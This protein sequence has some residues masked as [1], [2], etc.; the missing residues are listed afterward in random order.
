[1][2]NW[3][4]ALARFQIHHTC[5]RGP[6][7]INRSNN[8]ICRR[9]ITA[10]VTR[11]KR[12]MSALFEERGFQIQ[13][14]SEWWRLTTDDGGKRNWE[15]TITER[16]YFGHNL[17]SWVLGR[18]DLPEWIQKTNYPLAGCWPFDVL[19]QRITAELEF[20]P[21]P[22]RCTGDI[23]LHLKV[24]TFY[25]KWSATWDLAHFRLAR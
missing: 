8:M 4:L 22:F 9:W 5:P 23:V 12:L 18:F 10:L 2:W 20:F 13:E 6:Q 16:H 21:S 3:K 15:S 17:S 7:E 24:Y 1:M 19:Q 11:V 25:S 14:V